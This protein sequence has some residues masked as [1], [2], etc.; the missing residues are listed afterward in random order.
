L[1]LFKRPWPRKEDNGRRINGFN[2]WKDLYLNAYPTGYAIVREYLPFEINNERDID[3][4]CS[5]K[6]R[7][8]TTPRSRTL[9]WLGEYKAL[10]RNKGSKIKLGQ[11]N[12]GSREVADTSFQK[13]L[14]RA[15]I[16]LTAN[17]KD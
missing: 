7:G 11:L 4:I 17:P 12:D 6:G 15:E 3:V 13:T 5:L 9:A 8:D 2:D 1:A 10:D 14:K 16:I